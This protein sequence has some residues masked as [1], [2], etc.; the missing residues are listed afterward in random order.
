MECGSNWDCRNESHA[1]WTT[2]VNKLMEDGRTWCRLK[3]VCL[4]RKDLLIRKLLL[5]YRVQLVCLYTFR[6]QTTCPVSEYLPSV[7]RP[8]MS[9]LPLQKLHFVQQSAF[10]FTFW[11]E[12][13]GN[14][15]L[16]FVKYTCGCIKGGVTGGS[17]GTYGEKNVFW[18]GNPKERDNLEDLVADG[19]VTSKPILS[20]I[21]GFG[22]K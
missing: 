14:T 20:E 12:L 10:V 18:L 16:V 1:H 22:S 3:A 6:N 19:T 9:P 5:F 13:V 8:A 15:C 4:P 21:G 11:F 17:C 7:I 2:F